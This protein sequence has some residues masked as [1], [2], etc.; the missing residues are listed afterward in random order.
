MSDKLAKILIVI[1]L[2]LL[3]WAWAFLSQEKEESFH[4][5]LEIS[6]QADPGLLISF[7]V[8]GI[9][10]GRR[11]PLKLNF[12]GTPAK[13]SELSQKAKLTPQNDSQRE[14]LDYPYDPTYYGHTETKTYTFD[15]LDFLQRHT[16]TKQLAL[17]L[18]SCEVAETPVTQ[19]EVEVEVL[20]K[21]WVTIRCLNE[22]DVLE[23]DAIIDP[24]T[25]EMYVRKGDP[26]EANIQLS[27]EQ[28]D[29]A[30]KQPVLAKPF[31]Q[32]GTEGRRVAAES[33]SVTLP[34]L[35]E[36]K[37]RPFQTNKPIG[38]IMSEKL[39]N[40]YKVKIENL[41]EL[42]STFLIKATDEAYSAYEKNMPYQLLIEIRD[43]DATA[44]PVPP[45]TVIFNFPPEYIRT[46]QI[47]LA[48]PTVART[49]LANIK[50]VPITA[51]TP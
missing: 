36:L 10:Y 19:I 41:S 29:R 11:V 38:L 5:S 31:V 14:R 49:R 7:S 12:T 18:D 13:I 46:D 40:E 23:P 35:S 42:R 25:I 22:N 32:L 15:M 43:S 6:S 34:Q 8:N 44:D 21:K 1:I 45:K 20:E 26:A 50:L 27:R 2:T 28:I 17:T 30:R 16:K 48:D 47:K 37:S 39:Q 4:G 24:A 3:I 33:V 9:E 51:P